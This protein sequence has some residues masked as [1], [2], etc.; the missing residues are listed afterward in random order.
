M[1]VS[2]Q[3]RSAPLA[4]RFYHHQ[5]PHCNHSSLPV[6]SGTHRPATWQPVNST[7]PIN[8]TDAIPLNTSSMDGKVQPQPVWLFPNGTALINGTILG[9]PNGTAFVN[10][11]MRGYPTITHSSITNLS[12]N[13]TA[14]N[15][16]SAT[17]PNTIAG[18]SLDAT[19]DSTSTASIATSKKPLSSSVLVPAILVPLLALILIAMACYAI[20]SNRKEKRAH[21]SAKR[22]LGPSESTEFGSSARLSRPPVEPACRAWISLQPSPHIS[23][24]NSI[25]R[26]NHESSRYSAASREDNCHNQMSPVSAYEESLQDPSSSSRRTSIVSALFYHPV[27]SQLPSVDDR[28]GQFM[29]PNF[30]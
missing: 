28:Q 7:T 21:E 22:E 29:P 25:A 2:T 4:G 6:H 5:H 1:P 8:G 15:L 3:V 11:T 27:Q 9:F 26:F 16:T 13:S 14:T 12:P 17:K 20:I 10:G 18:T 24:S 19:T 30:N 23:R